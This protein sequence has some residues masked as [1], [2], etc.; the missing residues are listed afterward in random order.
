MTQIDGL[1]KETFGTPC[2][3]VECGTGGCDNVYPMLA[4]SSASNLAI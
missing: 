3:F 4:F 2:T 1:P